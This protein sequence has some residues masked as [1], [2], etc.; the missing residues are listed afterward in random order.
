M[1][2]YKPNQDSVLQVTKEDYQNCTT[3]APLA[4]FNDGRTVFAF[5]K[6]GPH[7]FISGKKENCL[8]N[9][10]LVVIVLS[11]RSDSSTSPPGGMGIA[12]AGENSPTAGSIQLNPTPSPDEQTP[13]AASSTFV[14]LTGFVGTLF[15]LSLV[16]VF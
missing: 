9:E 16:F 3:T 14:S 13:S 11:E 12:P 8:K 4:T 10:K 1:F 5:K 7:Y 15:A 2:V 6:S